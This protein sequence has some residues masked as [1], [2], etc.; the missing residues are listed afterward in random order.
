MNKKLDFFAYIYAILI[1]ST[2]IGFSN[3]SCQSERAKINIA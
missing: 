1:R 2:E 3:F